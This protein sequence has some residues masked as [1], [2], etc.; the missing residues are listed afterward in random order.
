MSALDKD[1]QKEEEE[2]QKRKAKKERQ[3]H[4]E[5]ENLDKINLQQN[6]KIRHNYDLNKLCE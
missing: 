2:K 1:K 6:E 4:T 5:E 3:K